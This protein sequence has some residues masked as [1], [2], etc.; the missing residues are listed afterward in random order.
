[1]HFSSYISTFNVTEVYI[2]GSHIWTSGLVF[3]ALDSWSRVPV[4][5]TTGWLQ[6]RLSLWSFRGR[7]NEYKEFFGN[8]VVKSKLPRR[9][10]S[11]ALRQFNPIHK[12]GPS[13]FFYKYIGCLCVWSTNHEFA[14][15]FFSP[16][17]NNEI[18]GS[19]SVKYNYQGHYFL[20][21]STFLYSKIL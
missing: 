16:V 4:F 12:N 2:Y 10:G 6:G 18:N 9:S 20:H 8:L 3:R 1:M 19:A 15:N 13:S 5:K 7:S 21:R 11:V 17:P 14:F